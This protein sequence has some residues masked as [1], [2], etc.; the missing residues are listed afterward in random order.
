[1]KC[2][3][4]IIS[5]LLGILL[6]C[7]HD[8]QPQQRQVVSLNGQW[9]IAKTGGELPKVFT[10]T[11]SVPGVVDLAVPALDTVGTIYKDSSWYW[12]KRTFDLA[13]T[14]FEVIRLKIFKAKY[15]TKV[16]ING[17]FAGENAFCFTPSYFDVK[18]FLKPAGQTNEIMIGVGSKSQMPKGMPNGH[19]WEKIKYIPGIYDNVELTLSKRPFINNIQCVPDSKNEKLRVVA[20]IETDAP[21]ALTL[22]YTVSKSESGGGVVSKTISPKATVKDGYAVVD[23]EIDM[24][25][26]KL[27]T[28]EKPYLYELTLSTGADD[29]RVK[30][31]MRSFRFDTERKIALLNEKPYYLRGTNV[32]IF[33]F[34]EDPDRGTLPWDTQWVTTLHEKFKDMHW[35]MARYCIGFPPEQW[36]EICDSLGFMLQDEFP[37]WSDFEVPQIAEEYRRWMR[38]RWN[39]PSVV[40]WDAQNETVTKHTAEAAMQVRDL[41]LSNRPWE[42][43]YSEPMAA[44]DP[45]ESHPYRFGKYKNKGIVEPQEGYKKELFGKVSRPNNDASQQSLTTRGTDSIFPNPSI[46][47]EY[48]WIWLNRNGTTT[49]LTDMVYETLWQGSQL[50][51]QERL[52]L[53]GRH[54]AMLT[55]YWRAHRQA[56]GVL[57][58]CGLGYSRAEKPR[59]QT[60]D[61]WIDIRN[62]TYE[63]AF[64]QYVKPSFAPVGLMVDVWEKSYPPADKLTVPVYVI[65]DLEKPFNQKV[66]L[67]LL[68]DDKIVSEWYQKVDVKGYEVEIT[69]FEITLPEEVGDYLLKAEITVAGEQV[70]SLR[71]I[72]VVKPLPPMTLEEYFNETKPFNGP[73]TLSSAAP[74]VIN[75]YDF[76]YG[77]AGKAWRDS[78]TTNEG[79]GGAYRSNNGDPDCYVDID[80]G[81]HLPSNHKGAL[82]TGKIVG[83][84]W[85]YSGEW[86]CYTVDVKDAGKYEVVINMCSDTRNP[87]CHIELDGQDVTGVIS[88]TDTHG[89]R[90]YDWRPEHAVTI[91]FPAGKHKIKY[92]FEYETTEH[93]LG[94]L[95]FTFVKP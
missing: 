74:C 3:L 31:G 25:G 16:Y 5:L 48:G 12:H 54:L 18:P 14:D 49:T 19:D 44:T 30:F 89:W 17:Q 15:Q 68:K 32:C 57:H 95:K 29:K 62:L 22:A 4:F 50:T 52:Q 75:A 92:F 42:N 71:D 76:D 1:M 90:N 39:H 86:L 72:P 65:N 66:T 34:F 94:G 40:I 73:H 46:I 35:E 9:Q 79:D 63:P 43:G 88:L 7:Q 69:P 77:G 20:E 11:T 87:G 23:F 8:S 26:A 61:H 91:N 64:Y 67:T 78:N 47:N 82:R 36:Y 51:P 53:Y 6:S 56:A 59:G 10:S 27:W 70:F 58:F 45:A 93:N 81:V 80:N 28:P 55:E 21:E 37:I 60:S 41:D 38:E 2:N 83:V 84:G 33:R 24:K 13:N 85:A